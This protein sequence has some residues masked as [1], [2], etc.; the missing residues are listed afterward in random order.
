MDKVAD[1]LG[2]ALSHHDVSASCGP[3]GMIACTCSRLLLAQGLT[4]GSL[5]SFGRTDGCDLVLVC[6]LSCGPA[7]ELYMQQ[8]E[9]LAIEA[10]ATD[11]SEE[12]LSHLPASW[13]PC[14]CLGSRLRCMHSVG[15]APFMATLLCMAS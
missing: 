5:A 14:A 6:R 15:T 3:A 1:A 9:N 10:A 13:R 8:L 2:S 4:D 7:E 12:V 11:F